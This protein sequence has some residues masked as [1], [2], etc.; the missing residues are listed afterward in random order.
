MNDK[1]LCFKIDG[2][3]L[4][5]EISLIYFNEIPIFFLCRDDNGAMYAVQCIDTEDLNYYVVRVSEKNTLELL[6]DTLT[7]R[8]FIISS[9]EKWEIKSRENIEDDIVKQIQTINEEDLVN[10]GVFLSLNN[11]EVVTFKEKINNEVNFGLIRQKYQDAVAAKIKIS[12]TTVVNAKDFHVYNKQLN[13]FTH[14]NKLIPFTSKTDIYEK[15]SNSGISNIMRQPTKIGGYKASS[16][17]LVV[18]KLLEQ[19]LTQIM[20]ESKKFTSHFCS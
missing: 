11:N 18:K 5:L 7:I 14:P 1:I 17:N 6:N 2:N 16:K 15:N 19:E 3:N 20:V 13:D 8:E 9:Y 12:E 4:Y 10:E